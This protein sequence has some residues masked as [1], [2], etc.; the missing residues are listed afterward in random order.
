MIKYPIT[1]ITFAT[2]TAF[3]E[4]AARLLQIEH[5]IM[6]AWFSPQKPVITLEEYQKLRAAVQIEWPYSDGKL[7]KTEWQRYLE[8]RFNVKMGKLVDERCNL[9][10]LLYTSTR[11]SPNLDDAII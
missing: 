9:K 7:S 11:F 6:G 10:E 2:K 5:N 3:V 1:C 8:T 4:R